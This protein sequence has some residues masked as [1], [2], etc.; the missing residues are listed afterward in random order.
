MSTFKPDASF[1]DMPASSYDMP[2]P[3]VLKTDNDRQHLMAELLRREMA[4][5]PSDSKQ[6]PDTGA[7]TE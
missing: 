5:M 7:D 3:D 6:K 4:N 1:D 2:M